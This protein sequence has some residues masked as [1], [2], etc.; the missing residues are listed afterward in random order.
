VKLHQKVKM[1]ITR[2]KKKPIESRAD[3]EDR[4]NSVKNQDITQEKREKI[5]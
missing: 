2:V 5:R 3:P 1:D 4:V